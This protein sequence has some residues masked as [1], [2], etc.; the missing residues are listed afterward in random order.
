MTRRVIITIIVCA[1]VL[2]FALTYL[3]FDPAGYDI[4]PKCQFLLAIGYKC[5]GCGS[6]RA[7]HALLNG[8]FIAAV[9]FNAIFI[10]SLPIICI[11][12]YG[13]VMKKNHTKFF[14]VINSKWAIYSLL[15]MY[16][17]WWVLRNV[18]NW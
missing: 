3:F 12:A 14:R 4:F 6:Q 5:P 9:K 16:L 17:A 10:I 2:A 7:I 1:I 15:F 11:Y 13:E 18:F 8:D